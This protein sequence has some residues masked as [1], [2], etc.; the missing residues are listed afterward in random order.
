MSILQNEPN[1]YHRADREIGVP[2]AIVQNEPNFRRCRVGETRREKGNRAK[3]SQ[4]GGGARKW[5]QWAGHHEG[6]WAKRSQRMEARTMRP[7]V[8]TPACPARPVA[9]TKNAC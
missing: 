1:F 3:R 2:R 9:A 7:A 8:W 6:N 4:F 5:A